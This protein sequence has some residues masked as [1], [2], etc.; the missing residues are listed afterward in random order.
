M[1]SPF[2]T[3]TLDTSIQYEAAPDPNR[4][5]LSVEF[6]DQYG[7]P[8]ATINNWTS[9]NLERDFFIPADGFVLELQDDRATQLNAQL[10]LGMAVLFKINNNTIMTGYIFDYNLSYDKKAGQKLTISGKDLLGYMEIA[11][12]YPNLG[13]VDSNTN[14]HFKATDTIQT[15]LQT[16]FNAFTAEAQL[17]Q[18]ITVDV[19]DGEYLTFATGFATGIARRGKSARGIASSLRRNLGHLT[20]PNKGETY[21][22]YAIRI[23]KHIGA[24]IKM[25]PGTND[26]IIVSA[27]TYDREGN[28]I[29]HYLVNAID[30]PSYNNIL[31]GNIKYSISSQP[32]VVIVE[33]ATA[34][35]NVY[36]KSVFKAIVINELTGYD[37]NP[38]FDDYTLDNAIPN[39]K[40]AIKQL[41]NNQK[42]MLGGQTS[43]TGY[44]LL[45][46]NN[47]I[48]VKISGSPNLP[49]NVQT[50]ASVPK[51]FVDSNAHTNDECIFAAAMAMAEAQD[52]FI[53]INYSVKGFTQFGAVW[54]P[55]LMTH[56][57]D[58]D[59]NI[60]SDFWIKKV[61]FTRTRTSGTITHLELTLPYTHNFKL[62]K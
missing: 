3:Q 13:S 19:E 4:D 15:A 26:T 10:Q 11:V 54:Y 41:T 31:N 1:T 52:K 47:D 43:S 36:Y 9:F 8:T 18:K 62:D 2:P 55:N 42:V 25:S 27:P 5:D 51:Y 40:S 59:L 29:P 14:F 24:N 57:V 21:L 35:N 32:S 6:L 16:I 58:E 45:P 7:N 60:E 23:C 37:P 53:V 33:M 49:P 50:Q 28:Q 46:P 12:C 61:N 56:V 34:G 38:A 39:V 17:P 22:S 30:D 20:A 48:N 44:Y